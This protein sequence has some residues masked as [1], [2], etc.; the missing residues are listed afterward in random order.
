MFDTLSW[1]PKNLVQTQTQQQSQKENPV[2]NSSVAFV[3][4]TRGP[5]PLRL[6][7]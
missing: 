6:H 4:G 7:C 5:V 2:F 3:T 1:T